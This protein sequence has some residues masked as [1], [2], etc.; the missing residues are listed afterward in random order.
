MSQS[1]KLW[2]K[3]YSLTT[4]LRMLDI[5]LAGCLKWPTDDKF[6]LLGKYNL[7]SPENR[8]SSRERTGVFLS[9]LCQTWIR[10]L[11]YL[12]ISGSIFWFP[13]FA[14]L[15]WKMHISVLK[16]LDLTCKADDK[17]IGFW[18]AV[19]FVFVHLALFAF[20]GCNNSE[21]MLGWVLSLCFILTS[22]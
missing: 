18:V 12:C 13:Q 15:L 6:L 22:L 5:W 10:I 7:W 11:A 17:F 16:L 19:K 2:L 14:H 21:C 20:L 1:F 3:T 9:K 8:S 4:I